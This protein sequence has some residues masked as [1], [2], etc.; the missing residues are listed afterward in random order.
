VG[1]LERRLARL[2]D[3]RRRG[4]AELSQEALRHLS[5]EDLAALEGALGAEHVTWEPEE[6]AARVAEVEAHQRA[7]AEESRR[8]DR[9]LLARNRALAGLPPLK[10]EG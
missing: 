6:M 8:W 5:D 9:E 2:E 3:G 7:R 1:S 4:D 10:G